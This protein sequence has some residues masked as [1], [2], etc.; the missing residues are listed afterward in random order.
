MPISNGPP[1]RRE[2]RRAR[3]RR[4]APRRQHGVALI[5]VLMVVVTASAFVMLSALNNRAS[6]ETA[7]RLVTAEALGQARRALLGYAVGYADGVHTI[8]KGPG[9]LPCPDVAGG[10]DQGVAESIGDCRVSADRETGLL[11]FRTLGLTALVDGSG[12]P[13]W[14][15]VAEN[16]RSM[17]TS[18]INDNTVG[19]L[20]VDDLSDVA[21]VIIAPGAPLV[22]QGRG[23]A[24]AY[25]PAAWLEGENASAG[26]NRFTRLMDAANNDT[27]MVI[28]RGE[29]MAEVA[30]VVNREVQLALGN[31]Y[32]D[33]DGDDDASG[34]DPQCASADPECDNAMP[35]LAPRTSGLDI[36]V[37]G[38]GR[39]ALAR[40]P[41]A[42]LNK[43]FDASFTALWSLDGTGTVQFTGTAPPAENC[44]RHNFCTQMINDK[45]VSGTPTP[46]PVF[47]PAPLLGTAA[48]PWG[49]GSCVLS[50]PKA[51][52]Y[53]L[54]MN[55]HT[56][57]SYSV[58]GRA[59]RREWQLEIRGNTRLVPPTAGARRS[60]EVRALGLWPVGTVGRITV[61]DFE[62]STLLGTA[63]LEFSAFVGGNTF[64]LLNVPFD[65]ELWTSTATIDRHLSPGA[66]P[67]WLHA[68][69]WLD[70]VLLR[71]ATSEAPGYSGAT[72]TVAGTCLRMQLTR[73]GETVS[74]TD[75]TLRGV[76]LTA[77]PPLSAV[78]S[79]ATPAQVRPS[80]D[81]KDFLE[82]L[83][84]IDGNTYE[85]RDA[86]STFNDEILP[87]L[88]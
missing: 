43:S 38:E 34:A 15:A 29:L 21:A 28:T 13:L 75:N 33:P 54:V 67:Q 61:S 11:P 24:S 36:G 44:V 57:Y 25:T 37:V 18:A 5:L 71:Y 17:T 47:F 88:P 50:R 35:W 80:L 2:A 42:Q 53:T 7:Q 16:F 39:T 79:P 4:R 46:T 32:T 66:L 81:L 56:Q 55:C 70:S 58:P 3:A 60:I 72:C 49:Q 85:R 64:V 22:G 10:S 87:L 82:G 69:Q 8:D 31:Y 48:A 52:A 30:K 23:S 59:L 6:R 19:N 73:S 78:V 1:R 45:P 26:D 40:L 9:R 51:L 20:R 76:V 12:A 41:I 62:G 14:Y 83:N 63:M 84:K 68:D 27:V 86:S 65:L 77:G 74:T